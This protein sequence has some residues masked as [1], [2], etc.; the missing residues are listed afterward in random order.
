MQRR[1]DERAP[2]D[3]EHEGAAGVVRRVL[4][5][6][7]LGQQVTCKFQML[8]EFQVTK[9][10]NYPNFFLTYLRN[11]ITCRIIKLVL[12]SI[13]KTFIYNG[14]TC[15]VKDGGRDRLGA[16]GV[17][18]QP[19]QVPPPGARSP[20]APTAPTTASF[21][22]RVTACAGAY[23]GEQKLG[24]KVDSGGGQKRT[25]ATRRRK[26]IVPLP[27]PFEAWSLVENCRE[28]P[29]GGRWDRAEDWD[30]RVGKVRQL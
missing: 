1:A 30:G 2:E 15:A 25:K 17:V 27:P 28:G 16:H 7:E 21:T 26:L 14:R 11:K 10:T 19:V 12:I 5:D 9:N 13:K 20:L 22:A 6:Q 18:R 4:L 23:I 29:K 3:G 24:E 8:G